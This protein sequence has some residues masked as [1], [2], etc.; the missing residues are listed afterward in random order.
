MFDVTKAVAHIENKPA[1]V[2]VLPVVK[3]SDSAAA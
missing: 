2:T 1:G 3:K